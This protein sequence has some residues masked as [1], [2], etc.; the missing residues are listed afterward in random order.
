MQFSTSIIAASAALAARTS[1]A[2]PLQARVENCDPAQQPFNLTVTSLSSGRYENA[3]LN[4][5]HS[6]AAE[7]ALAVLPSGSATSFTFNTTGYSTI[8]GYCGVGYLQYAAPTQPTA[9]V[10]QMQF[11]QN[12]T[13]NVE[14]AF[15]GEGNGPVEL[16]ISNTGEIFHFDGSSGATAY[17]YV[18]PQT[19]LGYTYETLSYVMDG[20]T[21]TN[22][23]CDQVTVKK[24]GGA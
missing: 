21:P 16:T 23:D 7:E 5:A 18:C 17:W 14:A 19:S 6:G 4:A 12:S 9:T 10:Q 22:P 8:P 20:S 15:F 13:S 24:V 2:A 1:L 3:L 11:V